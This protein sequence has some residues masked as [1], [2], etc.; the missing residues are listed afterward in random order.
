MS[1]V[2]RYA[3]RLTIAAVAA[4]CLTLAVLLAWYFRAEIVA[5]GALLVMGRFVWRRAFP[6]VRRR[7]GAG[8]R[9]RTLREW[10]DVGLLALIAHRMPPRAKREP[11][12]T[13]PTPVY[14]WRKPRE[15]DPG[16]QLGPEEPWPGEGL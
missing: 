1:A 10:A 8:S 9:V 2:D 12:A 11:I 15:S 4:F 16:S 5:A 6:P 14:G 3:H 13:T 7:G